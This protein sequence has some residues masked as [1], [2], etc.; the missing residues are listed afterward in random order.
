MDHELGVAGENV[1]IA[2]AV[3]H[4][5]PELDRDRPD[6]TIDQVAGRLSTTAASPEKKRGPVEAG[7]LDGQ[8]DSARHQTAQTVEMALVACAGEEFHA[9]G[10]ASCE[11]TSERRI[12]TPAGRRAR[13]PKKL[14]P[15]GRV[16]QNQETRVRRIVARSPSQPD[17]RR[18]RASSRL[19]A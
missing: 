19:S 12:H 2:I 7:W 15:R 18:R 1:E 17:P 11:L 13:V 10:V 9:D 16:D 8:G 14:D 5:N 6:Q 4:R 3:E